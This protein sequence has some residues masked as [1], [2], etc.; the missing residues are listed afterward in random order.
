MSIL[1]THCCRVG[2]AIRPLE[3][4]AVGGQ[5]GKGRELCQL[6]SKSHWWAWVPEHLVWVRTRLGDGEHAVVGGLFLCGATLGSGNFLSKSPGKRLE[7]KCLLSQGRGSTGHQGP[8]TK[9]N[10]NLKAVW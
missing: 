10:L 2:A 8:K 4:S 6:E 5:E 7:Q 3:L 1:A 9:E